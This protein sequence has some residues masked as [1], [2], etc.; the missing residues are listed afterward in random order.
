MRYLRGPFVGHIRG[1]L[2]SVSRKCEVG[3]HDKEAV[4][5]KIMDAQLRIPGLV[6]GLHSVA[7]TL[8]VMGLQWFRR[9]GMGSGPV[10]A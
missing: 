6:S 8:L 2:C 9:L 7:L 4:D 10:E 1:D 5:K 3:Q